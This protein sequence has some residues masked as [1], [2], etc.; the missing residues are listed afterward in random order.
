MMGT[1]GSADQ[2]VDVAQ[3]YHVNFMRGQEQRLSSIKRKVRYR[4]GWLATGWLAM[5][6]QEAEAASWGRG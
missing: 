3:F 6:G 5:P 1:N 2:R 4:A